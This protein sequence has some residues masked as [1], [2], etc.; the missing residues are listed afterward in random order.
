MKVASIA[1]ALLCL[2][3]ASAHADPMVVTFTGQWWAQANTPIGGVQQVPISVPK[4]FTISMTI[5]PNVNSF[6]TFVVNANYMTRFPAVTVETTATQ[7]GLANPFDPPYSVGSYATVSRYSA[8]YAPFKME[9]QN[10]GLRELSSGTLSD[11]ATGQWEMRLWISSPNIAV[12]LIRPI[13]GADLLASFATAQVEQRQYNIWYEKS[14]TVSTTSTITG[15]P[16][17][18]Y[19]GGIQLNGYAQ[20]TSVS[21][22]PDLPAA[23]SLGA[24]LILLVAN[25]AR[26]SSIQRKAR[27]GICD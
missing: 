11:G 26:Q 4:D 27:T 24:G 8:S 7:Y 16:Y 17:S 10:F 14:A 25:R 15:Y 12:N 3:G 21:A 23:W 1:A 9:S 13:T 22:V 2:L 6:E 5:D 19:I 18:G 20:I